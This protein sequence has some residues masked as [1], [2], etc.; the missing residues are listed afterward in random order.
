[1]AGASVY[2]GPR[3]TATPA[4]AAGIVGP[5]PVAQRMITSPGLAGVVVAPENVPAL[6]AKLKSWRVATGWL[7]GHGK[8]AGPYWLA[9][10]GNAA[11]VPPAVV[12]VTE[13]GPGATSGASTLIWPGERK[14]T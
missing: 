12:T 10:V 8:K 13:V 3:G 11:L 1:G 6:T 5:N 4:G 2:L 7:P 9:V 14:Y